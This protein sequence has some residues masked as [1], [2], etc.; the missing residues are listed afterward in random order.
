MRNYR[1]MLPFEPNSQEVP[2]ARHSGKRVWALPG[3]R[4]VVRA[5]SLAE[6]ERDA[7][8][9][10]ALGEG[11]G[12]PFRVQWQEDRRVS[13]IFPGADAYVEHLASP[14]QEEALG[15]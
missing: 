13:E 7:E 15:E 1:T 12:P 9:L 6:P 11:D 14:G 10:E 5:H 4:L 8:V 2:E 3:D